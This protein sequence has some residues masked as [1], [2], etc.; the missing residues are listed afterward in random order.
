MS[1]KKILQLRSSIGFFGAENVIAQLVSELA[2]TEY[3]PIIGVIKN[4]KNPHVELDDFAKGNGIESTIFECRGEF[5]LKLI[6]SVRNFIK[7]NNI[8]I[9]Q[10]HG[11]K[12]NFYA[13][14]ATLFENVPLIAT[15][16]PWIKISRRV[17]MYAKLD[18][19]LLRK[20]DRIVAISEEVKQE[21]LNAGIPD[22]KIATIDNGINVGRFE[23]QFDQK[24]IRKQFDIPMTSTVIGTVGRLSF[25]KGHNI[26]LEA[27]EKIIKKYPATFFI[28]AG[29]GKLKDELKRK[30]KQLKIE[31]HLILPGLINDIPGLLSIL[32]IFV[33][34]SLTEG[35]PMALLEAMA[36]KKPVVAARVG[37]I[38]KLIVPDETGL[39]VE[40]GDVSSLAKSIIELLTGKNKAAR[41]AE[42]GYRIIVAKFS[43]EAMAR[44]YMNIYDM[45]LNSDLNLN[46]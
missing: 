27:A 28:I 10:T 43:S 15:C 44:K 46:E 40:P 6:L 35:L 45:L 17:K 37:S 11:Y 22:K 32:D 1:K 20:F 4:Q 3:K 14:W 13:V 31:K 30:A 2:S 39:L 25:E 9:V 24:K 26:L 18:R 7:R 23:K 34:P 41:L 5:D 38:P 29:D 36:A 12:S 21:I 42:N 33:L 16:H 8:D 19:V